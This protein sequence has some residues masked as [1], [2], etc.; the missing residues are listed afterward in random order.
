MMIRI[1]DTEAGKQNNNF[2]TV[3]FVR[4]EAFIEG[5]CI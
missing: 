2:L 3:V 5:S 4:Y 1:T